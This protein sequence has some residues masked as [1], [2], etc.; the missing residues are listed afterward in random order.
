ME[1]E[2]SISNEKYVIKRDGRKKP[3]EV[4]AIR[5]AV[6]KAY[7]ECYY[8]NE[9]FN[10]KIGHIITEVNQKVYGRD[11]KEIDIEDIQDYVVEALDKVDKVVGKAYEEYREER[12]RIRDSK[13]KLYSDIEGILNGSNLKVLNEN[14][15]KKGYMN[16]TQRDLM[17]GELSK[18]MSRR[19]IPKDIMDAHDIGAIKIHD[20][21]YYVNNIFNCDL[22]N[23]DDM[24]QNGTVIN[25]KLIEKP[26]SIKTAMNIATQIAAQVASSQY[27]GQ[28]ISLTHLAPFVR[29][30]K[31]KIENKFSK[32]P[33]SEELR[34]QIIED[35]LK[36]EIKDAVQTF[37][38]Q[39]NT[40]QTCNG[41]SPF[42]SLCIYL[43]EDPEYSKEVAML[44]EE[45]F[46]QRLEG[47]KNKFGIKSTQTFPKLLYFLD[48]NNTYE[49]S[50]YFY[51]TKLAVEC[52]SVR[53]NPD[54]ISVKKMKQL[55]GYAFPCINNT[56]A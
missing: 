41:Q 38:Y 18:A 26:K 29:I 33:I 52:T 1:N 27:G 5:N 21:D 55:I 12:S 3:Y 9:Q 15:N 56:C 14:A 42:L 54:Y 23:L 11:E 46:K 45:F 7:E 32:Y 22:I 19:M 13:Q 31:N 49:G 37:N 35:E 10:E 4:S 44:A 34:E 8:S 25:N 50:E 40:L 51:L 17:A 16:S 2:R 47:M 39:I 24:L 43:N 48:E 36:T 53:M 30:S 6:K 28:T 20:R